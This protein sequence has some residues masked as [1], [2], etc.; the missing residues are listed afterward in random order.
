M[1]APFSGQSNENFLQGFSSEPSSNAKSILR[2]V[3]GQINVNGSHPS[4]QPA[5]NFNKCNVTINVNSSVSFKPDSKPRKRVSHRVRF[6][7]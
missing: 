5:C 1:S 4:R 7:R 6:R 3:L 2:S